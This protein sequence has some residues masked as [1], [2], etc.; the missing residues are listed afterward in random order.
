M[1]IAGGTGMIGSACVR[2]FSENQKY[3]IFHP[4]HQELDY[5]DRQAT[6]DFMQSNSIEQVI[7]AAGKVGGIIEN[8]DNPVALLDENAV[9]GLNAIWAAQQSGVE[10]MIILGSSCMYPINAQQPIQEDSLL[11]GDIEQTSIAYATAKIVTMQAALANNRQ[12]P[13]GTKFIPVIPNSTF[14]PNDD[15]DPLKSH[16]MAAL[17]RKIHTA[18]AEN[19]QQLELWGTGRPKREFIYVD[20][21]ARVF[22]YLLNYDFVGPIDLI[23][24]SPGV[25][26]SI[27][28]LADHIAGMIGYTGRITFDTSKPDGAMRKALSS[29]RLY[30]LGWDEYTDLKDGI[31][32]TYE[33]FLKNHA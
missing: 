8:R 15:F 19:L 3:T 14:G 16:V 23:N 4:T 25:E 22:S 5:T 13:D 24:I 31:Q 2:L 33:W 11:T 9:M 12:Y 18:K 1:L 32:Q 30:A 10:R 28:D 21:V 17:I 6:L 27:R 26:I 29:D 7:F 20:D